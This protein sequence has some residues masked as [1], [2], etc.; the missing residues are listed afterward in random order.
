MIIFFARPKARV[1][2][3]PVCK[4]VQ[5]LFTLRITLLIGFGLVLADLVAS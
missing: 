5:E 2:F 3:V 1:E 4:N